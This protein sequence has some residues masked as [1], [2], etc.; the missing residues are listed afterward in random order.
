[1]ASDSMGFKKRPAYYSETYVSRLQRA[2]QVSEQ[3]HH[4]HSAMNFDLSPSCRRISLQR[5]QNTDN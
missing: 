3:T 1:M 5:R 2:Q 4:I